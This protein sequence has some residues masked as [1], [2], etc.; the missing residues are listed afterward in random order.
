M[1]N[2]Q[3]RL[4]L[5]QARRSPRLKRQM[6][7]HLRFRLHL[8][9]RRYLNKRR[10]RVRSLGR[11][12]RFRRCSTWSRQALRLGQAMENIREESIFLSV[13]N[14]KNSLIYKSIV[15]IRHSFPIL[16]RRLLSLTFLVCFTEEF[17]LLKN[18]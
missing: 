14:K 6:P 2:L 17:D 7:L 12:C 9:N 11:R 13:V 1:S 15:F 3:Y 4:R 16:L 5:H 8:K 18:Q 10:Y